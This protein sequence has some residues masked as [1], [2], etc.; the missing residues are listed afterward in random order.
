MKWRKLRFASAIIVKKMDDIL[1]LFFSMTK[2]KNN[3]IVNVTYIYFNRQYYCRDLRIK[4]GA[5][6]LSPQLSLNA[7]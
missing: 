1:A 4:N 3:F 2:A 6:F 5:L 7:K